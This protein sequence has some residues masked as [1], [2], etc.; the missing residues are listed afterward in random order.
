[1]SIL[2]LPPE[3]LWLIAQHVG[4]A[5]LRTSVDY[6]T[7]A[8]K[9]YWAA[10][11]VFLS[12]LQLSTLYLSSYDVARLPYPKTALETL[13]QAK[14]ERLSLRFV[15]HPSKRT[16]MSCNYHHSQTPWHNQEGASDNE[17]S[18]FFEDQDQYDAYR[19]FE[20]DRWNDWPEGVQMYFDPHTRHRS[21]D[22]WESQLE[23]RLRVW[24]ACIN[25]KLFQL[26]GLLPAFQ[27]L[28]EL[29]IEASGVQGAPVTPKWNYL[30]DSSMGAIISH[31][32]ASLKS[33]TLDTCASGFVHNTKLVCPDNL[34]DRTHMC[35]ILAQRLHGLQSVRLRMQC[36]CPCLLK[37]STA[38]P[39]TVSKLK[40]LIIRLSLPGFTNTMYNCGN[41]RKKSDWESQ[42]CSPGQ[43]PLYQEMAIAGSQFAERNPSLKTMR[44]SY[45]DPDSY[46]LMAADCVGKRFMNDPN[47]YEN[48][49]CGAEWL[50][51][52]TG[53]T[54]EDRGPLKF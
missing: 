36:I 10:L 29:C 30:S 1:M 2:D 51:W 43:R 37:L 53:D 13:M 35:D 46:K 34:L 21:Q 5:E 52:E 38:P 28:R 23:G 6:L 27:N 18:C 49:D 33:L 22:F 17:E 40:S 44:V 12:G 54:L 31:L 19:R 20:D 7:V 39:G 45:T 50:P 41:Y 16:A 26:S 48:M 14:V 24:R 15:G 8:R 4:A 3:L 11:P 9:W 25:S 47:L 42:Q 32:P